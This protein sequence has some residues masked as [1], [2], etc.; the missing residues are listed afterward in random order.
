M[1]ARAGL[2]YA[3]RCAAVRCHAPQP[4]ALVRL[5]CFAH[6]GSGPMTYRHWAGALAPDV[7]LWQVNLPGRAGRAN[8]PFAR[9]WPPLV[10]ELGNAILS[11]VPEPFALFGH[12]L[13]AALAFEVARALT[14]AG[15]PPAHLVVASRS[16]P[17]VRNVHEVP[18]SD[19]EL[20]H[21]VDRLYDGVPDAVRSSNEVLGYFL[22]ILRAD[23]ELASAY[24][25][26]PG[27]LLRCPIT[28]LT[29]DGDPTVATQ[30]FERWARQ[31]AAD[32]ELHILPGG[33]FFLA[34]HEATL[35]ETIRGRLAG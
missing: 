19:A 4:A 25:I 21:H 8:E 18:A 32:C 35:L 9:S 23:L 31:T 5:V 13:G 20:L 24:A 14:R 29:G 17:D 6:A 12:S 3:D 33:H 28:A 1:T 27:P 22:P 16:A 15:A 7:E 30:D 10:E 34:D 11:D 26:G 2:V